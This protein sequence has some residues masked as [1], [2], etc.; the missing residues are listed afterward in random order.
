MNLFDYQLAEI[1]I[2]YS[3]K[4]PVKDRFRVTNSRDAFN[5]IQLFWPDF[6]TVEYFYVIYLNRANDILG[7]HQVSKGG[8]TA[9]VVD[10]Q[11]II[12]IALKSLA[13][14]IICFHNHPSGNLTPSD[15]DRTIS[16][17]LK[18]ACKLVDLQLLDH[19]IVCSDSF[20]SMADNADF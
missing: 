8:I 4:V 14:N 17:K 2:S 1:E 15:A 16:K 10:V 18:E 3:H 9:T 7:F 11:I 19:L 6:N 5:V 20:H 12:A 13:K